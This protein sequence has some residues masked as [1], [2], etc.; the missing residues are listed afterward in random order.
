[1]TVI[2]RPLWVLMSL[3]SLVAF[4]PISV[5]MYL[6][7]IHQVAQSLGVSVVQAQ[8][9]ITLYPIGYGIAQLI[10]GPVS[11][12]FGR[13]PVLF[14]SGSLYL[15]MTMGCYFAHSIGLLILFRILQAI[16]ACSGPLMARAMIRDIYNAER[17]AKVLAMIASVMGFAPAISPIVGGYL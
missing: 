5:E 12:R 16:G 8:L 17:C 15:F 10:L 14:F 13:K 6:P 11:D 9:T 4:G 2:K 3:M 7:A 1:M